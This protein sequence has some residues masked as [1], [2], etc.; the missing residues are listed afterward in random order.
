[1]S[2]LVCPKC[3]SDKILPR[4]VINEHNQIKVYPLVVAIEKDPKAFIFKNP[5]ESNLLAQ[6]C[7]ECGYVEFYVDS[8]KR[9]W[10]AY[11]SR[12]K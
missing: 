3:S 11:Q 2:K 1:M 10:S 8:P 7:G 9:L 12:K 5:I 4:I 6:V